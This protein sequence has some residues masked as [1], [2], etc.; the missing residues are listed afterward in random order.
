M[1]DWKDIEIFHVVKHII[2]RVSNRSFVG[3]NLCLSSGFPLKQKLTSSHRQEPQFYQT[4]NRLH[5][6]RSNGRGCLRFLPPFLRSWVSVVNFSLQTSGL[7]YTYVALPLPYSWIPRR[8]LD[9]LWILWNLKLLLVGKRARNWTWT[10]IRR[11][12]RQVLFWSTRR[13]ILNI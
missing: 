5:G 8:V 13:H 1:L 2:A 4:G 3:L 7:N 6:A 9:K 11:H 10:T 12:R